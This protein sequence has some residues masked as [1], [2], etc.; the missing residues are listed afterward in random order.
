M[1][2]SGRFLLNPMSAFDGRRWEIIFL[3][4]FVITSNLYNTWIVT[5]GQSEVLSETIPYVS[6][7]GYIFGGLFVGLGTRVSICLV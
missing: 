1:F 4:S 6:N 3:V 7:L 5:P 2:S